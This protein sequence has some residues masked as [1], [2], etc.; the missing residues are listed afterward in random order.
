[1]PS[2]NAL[3]RWLLEAEPPGLGLDLR[4]NELSIA[5]LS[6]KR[7][8]AELDLCVTSPLPPGCLQF[9]M[10]EPNIRDGDTLAQVIE[11]VLLRSGAAGSTRIALTLPD[12]IA[13]VS[14]VELPEAPRS[15]AEAVDLLKFRLKKTLPFDIDQT[16]LAYEPLAGAKPTYLTGVMHEAVVSQYEDFFTD[17]GFHVGIV[18]PA[19]VSLLRILSPFA[20]KNLSPGAD[21]FFVNVERE[22]FTVSLVRERGAPVLIRT[23]GLRT[24]DGPPVAYS[25]EDLLQD[26]IPTAIY[27]REK[28]RG[29]SLE[30]VY[31]RSLRPDLTHLREIL[32]E[33]FEAPSEPLNLMGA[34]S[35]ASDLHMDAT[36]ADSV[37][38]AAGAAF[39]RLA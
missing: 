23:L 28:L 8:K 9:N 5:R 33:Q 3:M 36:L 20:Q 34:V 27:Y 18:L 19:S 13:R 14:V 17:L 30:R 22:Y 16:R 29:T 10:L 2:G 24:S 31:Y 32:E 39:G 35:I 11:S 7:G 26:V 12:Y 21:Y 25:E 15:S 38:A 6:A 4:T 37:G 1:M